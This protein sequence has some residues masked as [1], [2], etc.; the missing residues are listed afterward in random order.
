MVT[1]STYET[2]KFKVANQMPIEARQESGGV[3]L[4]DGAELSRENLLQL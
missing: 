3:N 4:P 2:D 1:V